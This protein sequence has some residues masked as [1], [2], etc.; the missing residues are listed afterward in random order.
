MTHRA[1]SS[2]LPTLTLLPLLLVGCGGTEQDVDTE[3]P[4]EV[5]PRA[6]SDGTSDADITD[7]VA[8]PYLSWSDEEADPS[9]LG[10][11]LHDPDRAW[12]GI[13]LYTNDVDEAYLMDMSGRRLHTWKIPEQYDH[14]EHFEVLPGGQILAV[15]APQAL[16]KL[17][18]DSNVVWINDITAHHDVAMLSDGSMLVPFGE[19][20]RTFN[21]RQVGFDGIAHISPEGQ[22]L[23]RWSTFENLEDLRQHYPRIKLDE[24]PAADSLPEKPYDYFHLNTVEVL[25]DT[26]LGRSD[27]RF[28]A[29]NLLICLRNVHTIA[30]LDQDDWRVVW[31]WGYGELSFPHMP[32]MLDSGNLLIYDNGVRNKVTRVIEI[33]PASGELLWSYPSPPRRDFYS[34]RRGSNQRLPNGNTL[35]A[36]SE[37]G[38]VIEVTP[39]GDTVWEFWN[40]ELKGKQRKRIYRFM[41]QGRDELRDL[42]RSSK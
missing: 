34:M 1:R 8:L 23:D 12:D 21:G 26:P 29:G 38:H 6:S 4:T 20:L 42:I 36:E 32:T 27:D 17:D 9:Q 11:T 2:L 40:P 22:T 19:A 35:I 7:L 13:N 25:P 24:A 39:E 31:S 3:V 28:R 30:I 14:C 41:R 16:I 33:D 5:G 37:K 15:C 10:V 18:W